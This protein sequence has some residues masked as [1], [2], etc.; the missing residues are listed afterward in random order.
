[1]FKAGQLS[2]FIPKDD[3]FT[4]IAHAF[5][6]A[7]EVVRENYPKIDLLI[8]SV[9]KEVLLIIIKLFNFSSWF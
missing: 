1:M 3:T 8:L 4:F 7:A 6:C 2:V 9:K 5:H